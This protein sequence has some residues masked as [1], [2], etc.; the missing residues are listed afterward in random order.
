MLEMGRK[1]IGGSQRAVEP[2]SDDVERLDLPL[3]VG[4]HVT[5]VQLDFVQP[6]GEDESGGPE[7]PAPGGRF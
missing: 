5:G 1:E 7:G 4:G 2:R 3:V 6:G